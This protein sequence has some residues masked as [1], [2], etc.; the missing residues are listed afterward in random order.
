MEILALS[1][2]WKTMAVL[3]V[4]AA[5]ILVL[6]ILAQKGKGSGLGGALG[7]MAGSSLL[8]TKT[9]D[10]FTW[11]TIV[12]AS[13]VLILPIMLGI[14]ANKSEKSFDMPQQVASPAKAADKTEVAVEDINAV[15]AKAAVADINAAAVKVETSLPDAN[16]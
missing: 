14:M 3:W 2:V 7:G 15:A 16:K 5:I 9:G 8:G 11:V 1:F 6:I 4:I 13:V 12:I 10:F